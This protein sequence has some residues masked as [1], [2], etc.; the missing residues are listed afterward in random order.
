MH[1]WL[2]CSSETLTFLTSLLD[3]RIEEF[4]YEKLDRKAP[5]RINNPELL[6]QY[7]IDAGTEFGPRTAATQCSSDCRGLRTS[8][9]QLRTGYPGSTNLPSNLTSSS[10]TSAGTDLDTAVE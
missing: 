10:T 1:A 9:P 3:A 2:L 5:S 7:M 4:V 6:G 8:I